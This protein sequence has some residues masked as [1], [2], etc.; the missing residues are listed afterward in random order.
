MS[1]KKVEDKKYT[2]VYASQAHSSPNINVPPITTPF[3]RDYRSSS[4]PKVTAISRQSELATKNYILKNSFPTNASFNS[5]YRRSSMPKDTGSIGTQLA[6]KNSTLKNGFMN[7][8]PNSAYRS[9]SMPK[10]TAI[11]KPE[12]V[13]PNSSLKNPST[14]NRDYRSASMSKFTESI[15]SKLATK[16][17]CLSSDQKYQPYG[18][19]TPIN[20]TNVITT[21]HT[22]RSYLERRS[23]TITSTSSFG[24][25]FG[26]TIGVNHKYDFGRSST[27]PII[28]TTSLNNRPLQT[29]TPSISNIPTTVKL[30]PKS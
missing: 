22:E 26:P 24:P 1:Y 5:D 29:I 16:D 2:P 3:N 7:S 12:I 19:Y 27:T 21:T 30:S 9:S 20:R 18:S 17:A 4:M 6:I 10:V 14:F 8:S 15:A 25:I 11:I 13:T 23:E 28:S